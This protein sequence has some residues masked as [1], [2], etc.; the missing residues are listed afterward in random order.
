MSTPRRASKA[1]RPTLA[2][3]FEPLEPR[4]LLASALLQDINLNVP[5]GVVSTNIAYNGFNYFNA[6]RESDPFPIL[7]KT[8]GTEAGTTVVGEFKVFVPRMDLP[9]NPYTTTK[10]SAVV[11]GSLY[12]AASTRNEVSPSLWKVTGSADP[13]R[14]AGVALSTSPFLAPQLTVAGGLLY[15]VAKGPSGGYEVFRTDGTDA[16]TF[17][18]KDV[19][20]GPGDAYAT[21]LTPVGNSLF[22]SASEPTSRSLWK[23]DGTNAGTLRVATLYN[24]APPPGTMIPAAETWT[25]IGDTL[26]FTS[27]DPNIG[28]PRYSFGLYKSDG[29]EAGTVRVKTFSPPT[30]LSGNVLSFSHL[31]TFKGSVYFV[32]GGDRSVNGLWKSDGTEA[33][34]ARLSAIMPV[35]GATGWAAPPEFV[36]LGDSLFFPATDFDITHLWKTDGTEAGTVPVSIGDGSPAYPRSLTQVGS[37]IYFVA[38]S[39]ISYYHDSNAELWKTDGTA[40]GTSI[41]KEINPTGDAFSLKFGPNDPIQFDPSF[42]VVGRS[43]YFDANDGTHGITLFKTDGTAEG[44]ELVYQ[45]QT[46]TGSSNPVNA[47]ALGQYTLFLSP[48]GGLWRT[49]GTPLGTK[50]VTS[51]VTPIGPLIAF[52]GRAYFAG[53]DL[54]HGTEIW[55]TDGTDAGTSIIRDIFPGVNYSTPGNLTVGGT[56]LYFTITDPDVGQQLYKTDGTAQGTSVVKV[57]RSL[58]PEGSSISKLAFLN[59]LLYFTADDG[60]HGAEPWKTDGTAAGTVMIVDLQP[61]FVGSSPS[62]FRAAGDL[63]IF[64]AL[65]FPGNGSL[66]WRTDG[67]AAGTYVIMDGKTGVNLDGRFMDLRAAVNLNGLLYLTS[68]IARPY[69][70]LP[71]DTQGLLWQ[72]DGTEAG[73]VPVGLDPSINKITSLTAFNGGIAFVSAGN[74]LYVSDGTVA[75]TTLL[76]TFSVGIFGEFALAGGRLYFSADDGVHGRELWSTDGT[77]GGTV[78]AAD[79]I[80]G[81]LSS[82]ASPLAAIGSR[83]LVS[84]YDGIHGNEPW[85]VGDTLPAPRTPNDFDGDGKADLGVYMP[86]SARWVIRNSSGAAATATVWGN[87]AGLTN[88]L[89][90][91][92][93][94]DGVAD[95]AAYDRGSATWY[96]KQSSGAPPIAAVWGRAGSN[97]LPVV[98]DF[99]GDG[100]A[101]LAVYNPDTAQWFIRYTSGAAPQVIVWGGA[102]S[103]DIP[104]AADF[105]GDGLADLGVFQPRSGQWIVRNSADLSATVFVWGSSQRVDA[106]MAADYDGDGRAD[107][108]VYMAQTAL[109]AIRPSAGGAD[110]F[111]VWGL[112]YTDI[113]LTGD[114]DGDGQAD[115]AV[116]RPS[117]A[118]WFIRN[119]SDLSTTAVV[120]G[121]AG[122]YDNP[123]IQGFRFTVAYAAAGKQES[124]S[125]PAGAL[126]SQSI[127]PPPAAKATSRA[128]VPN[129]TPR[130]HLL[131]AAPRRT[132]APAE[133]PATVSGLKRSMG[134]AVLA[135]A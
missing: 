69:Y 52:K 53:G 45:T 22:F 18:L 76:K 40:A 63:V 23:T 90:G 30:D 126:A 24:N 57:I 123:L 110:R 105:D 94:N 36:A 14:V 77:P 89:S 55:S 130:A 129:P 28:P 88:V 21:N 104:V 68:S 91:D 120:W 73:T 80:A 83:V 32:A 66:L 49:D 43:V 99:D 2:P 95:L 51:R 47:V 112:A 127:A 101:D 44:T 65:D 6:A 72:S 13:V 111:A 122:S 58:R 124:G 70:P 64:T 117:R 56:L 46:G 9:N 38:S 135:P 79:I 59:G 12:F 87:A 29:T 121:R 109:W 133:A 93:D 82:Y 134:G 41:V 37:S 42:A 102:G 1:L 115:L 4:Q 26:Y 5:N 27:Y 85:V 33:G 34:T 61:G 119:S 107:F 132:S 74:A 7:Y 103:E 125:A 100:R 35:S 106:P 118:Q 98:A 20:A 54:E 11:G 96:V 114:Y 19:M 15:F 97:D 8:D 81:K 67:T 84:A 78:L 10:T 50:Q 62:N 3:N 128:A 108:A 113:P 39:S 75:G 31:A 25:S 92:F 16:G 71:S 86:D 131:G 48:I 60:V 17:V 116:Y